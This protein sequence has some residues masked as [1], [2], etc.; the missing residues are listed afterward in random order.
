MKHKLIQCLMLIAVLLTSSH[1]FAHDFEV[2][3]IYY[4]ITSSTDKTC[5]VTYKGSYS[6]QFSDEYTGSIVIPETVTYNGT[7]YSVTRIGYYAFSGC[8]SLTSITIPNSVI[9]IGEFA[10]S[11]CN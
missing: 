6:Y 4:Y 3:G 2:G 7:T 9:S 10:F 5:E 11:G 1:A 8:T